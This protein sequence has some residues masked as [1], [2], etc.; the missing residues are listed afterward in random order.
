MT[1]RMF[2]PAGLAAAL[3][4]AACG[5]SKAEGDGSASHTLNPVR[6]HGVAGRC[7]VTAPNGKRPGSDDGFNHGNRSL[8]VALWPEGRLV[9]GRLPDG[10]SYAEIK[11][12]GSIV[13]KLGWWRDIEGPLRIEGERLD[14]RSAPLRADV[15]AGYGPTG[16]QPSLLT[17]PTPG[18]WKVVGNIGRANLRF[19]VLVRKR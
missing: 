14:D 8:A 17:F 4:L 5:G 2:A 11:P 12:N 6:A 13:A 1:A 19:V 18:C 7:P 9:A 15:P 3:M 16:F 10:S